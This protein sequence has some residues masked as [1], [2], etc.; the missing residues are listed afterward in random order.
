MVRPATEAD[1]LPS[2][3]RLLAGYGLAAAFAITLGLL[4]GTSRTVRGFLEPVLE[5]FRAIPPPLLVPIFM[6]MLGIATG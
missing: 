2:I 6:L 3:L 5:F 1:A 4:I